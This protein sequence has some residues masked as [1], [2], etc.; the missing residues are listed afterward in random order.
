MRYQSILFWSTKTNE[1][2]VNAAFCHHLVATLLFITFITIIITDVFN[3]SKTLLYAV[4]LSA[5][6]NCSFFLEP[7]LQFAVILGLFICKFIIL[8]PI[9]RSLSIAY[10]DFHLCQFIAKGGI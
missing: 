5:I 7:I 2:T 4:F 1:R 3:Y 8:E 10:N 9:F 6:D